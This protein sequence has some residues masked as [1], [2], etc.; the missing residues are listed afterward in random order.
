MD[1]FDSVNN[2]IKF[3]QID[4]FKKM[5]KTAPEKSLVIKKKKIQLT[6]LNECRC[7]NF[8]KIG[9]PRASQFK[10]HPN[11]QNLSYGQYVN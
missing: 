10:H 4:H 8:S 7:K 11:C 1:V 9:L 6:K 2:I 5:T 3:E